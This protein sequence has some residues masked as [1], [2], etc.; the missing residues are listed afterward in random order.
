M[1]IF[2]HEL[3]ADYLKTA[4]TEF[5]FKRKIHISLKTLMYTS[6]TCMFQGLFKAVILE[7]KCV[8]NVT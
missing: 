2:P 7:N 8:T 6:C 5:N 4:K 1:D 3:H